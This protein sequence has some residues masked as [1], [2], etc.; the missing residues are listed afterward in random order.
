[1]SKLQNSIDE[2]GNEE[3]DEEFEDPLPSEEDLKFEAELQQEE[4]ID[5]INELYIELRWYTRDE[6]YDENIID[7][8]TLYDIVESLITI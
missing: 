1:M 2:F 7:Y 4:L 8:N 5:F 3:N 6:G